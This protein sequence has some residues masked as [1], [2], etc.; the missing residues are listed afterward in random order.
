MVIRCTIK[1]RIID[2]DHT[3][4]VSAI[5]KQSD[6]CSQ[7]YTTDRFEIS[8]ELNDDDH[9]ITDSICIY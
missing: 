9:M 7:E 8:E 2:S 5:L 6:S 3:R 1:R 4:N